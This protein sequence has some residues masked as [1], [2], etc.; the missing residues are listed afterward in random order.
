MM[1]THLQLAVAT[2]GVIT[3]GVIFVGVGSHH[4]TR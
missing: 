2:V 4:G 1:V 3:V